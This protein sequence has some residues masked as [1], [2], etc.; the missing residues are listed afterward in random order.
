MK[1]AFFLVILGVLGGCAAHPGAKVESD[2]ATKNEALEGRPCAD[3]SSCSAWE[4]CDRLLCIPERP[5][6]SSGVC[7]DQT[8]FFDTTGAAIPDSKSVGV[9]RTLT[10]RR[11]DAT[12]ASVA[13]NVSIAHTYQGDLQVV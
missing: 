13:V 1:T 10:V 3:D 5:C 2:L 8:S 11:P 6:S 9:T 7:R 12:V 4:F